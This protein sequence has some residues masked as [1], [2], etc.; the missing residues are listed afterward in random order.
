MASSPPPF[1]GVDVGQWLGLMSRFMQGPE[2]AMRVYRE[3]LGLESASRERTVEFL[4]QLVRGSGLDA[5]PFFESV[6]RFGPTPAARVAAAAY[7]AEQGKEDAV[8]AA[9]ESLEPPLL[10]LGLLRGLLDVLGARPATAAR[11]ERLV[12]F[13]RRFDESARY[14][15]V[16]MGEFTGR[17]VRR[18]VRGAIAESLLH[19]DAKEAAPWPRD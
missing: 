17:D 4:A 3:L 6:L 1:P 12:A 7:L 8:L 19:R 10:T 9:L 13:G 18:A 11:V 2:E 15:T 16:L 14:T 5:S